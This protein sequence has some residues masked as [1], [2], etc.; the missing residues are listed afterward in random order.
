[1]AYTEKTI[2]RFMDKISKRKDGCWDWKSA[3]FNDGYGYFSYGSRKEGNYRTYRAHRFSYLLFKGEIPEE[4]CVCHTC[5]NP[6]CVNPNHLFLGSRSDN[7]RDMYNKGRGVNNRG[8]NHGMS[9][10]KEK[11]IKLIFKLRKKGLTQAVIG[12]NFGVGQDSISRILNHRRW[13]YGGIYS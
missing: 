13:G 12:R 1:M 3:F 2:I 7:T 4:I 5:D 6:K 10:L 11:D 9:K 8:E